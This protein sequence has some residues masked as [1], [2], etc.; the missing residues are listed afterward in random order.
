MS[1]KLINQAIIDPRL[2]TLPESKCSLLETLEGSLRRNKK[3]AVFIRN[4]IVVEIT[5]DNEYGPS[6]F[7]SVQHNRVQFHHLKEI[8]ST[9][10]YEAAKMMAFVQKYNPMHLCLRLDVNVEI[11]DY[12][13]VFGSTTINIKIGW[14]RRY[15]NV[16]YFGVVPLIV[17]LFHSESFPSEDLEIKKLPKDDCVYVSKFDQMKLSYDRTD[18]QQPGCEFLEIHPILV[19]HNAFVDDFQTLIALATGYSYVEIQGG[20]SPIRDFSNTVFPCIWVVVYGE[21]RDI[22]KKCNLCELPAKFECELCDKV[23]FC[24]KDCW[25][26][27]TKHR[28]CIPFCDETICSFI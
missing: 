17:A 20:S 10:H 27:D 18:F 21:K 13:S 19:P 3:Y 28:F 8:F 16:F 15:K 24:S 14:L 2:R 26:F 22:V 11:E 9:F 25:R 1:L 12:G 7:V 6:F 23:S 5:L 4:G